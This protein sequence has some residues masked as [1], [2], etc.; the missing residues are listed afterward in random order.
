MRNQGFKDLKILGVIGDKQLTWS[1]AMEHTIRKH[2]KELEKGGN[3]A[4]I[5]VTT[6]CPVILHTVNRMDHPL[7][8]IPLEPNNKNYTPDTIKLAIKNM[9]EECHRLLVYGGED[10]TVKKIVRLAKIKKKRVIRIRR[11]ND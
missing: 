3:A 5:C 11:R 10:D 8:T 4:W 1:S 6:Y 9:A 2:F 7:M